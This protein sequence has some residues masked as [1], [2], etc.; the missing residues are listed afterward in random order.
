MQWLFDK[1]AVLWIRVVLI[2]ANGVFLLRQMGRGIE[3][4]WSIIVLTNWSVFLSIGS[5]IFS[6]MAGR[7]PDYVI[8][9]RRIFLI[10]Y[11]AGAEMFS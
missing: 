7:Y 11:K 10:N 3:P 6:N 2:F 1:K 8:S 9:K 5:L 4:Y